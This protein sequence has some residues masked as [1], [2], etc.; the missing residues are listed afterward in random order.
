MYSSQT[1]EALIIALARTIRSL[2][3]ALSL[4]ILSTNVAHSDT[5]FAEAFDDLVESYQNEIFE[6]RPLDATYAGKPEFN[7]KFEIG[8]SPE[9]RQRTIVLESKYLKEVGAIM[10]SNLSFEDS[11]R[12]QEFAFYRSRGLE[13]LNYPDHLMPLQLFFGVPQELAHLASTTD[14]QPF[15]TVDDYIDWAERL[16]LSA[17]WYEQATANYKLGLGSGI[18]QPQIVAVKVT[19]ALESIFPNDFV[20][21]PFY[22]PI[23]NLPADFSLSDRELITDLYAEIY[24]DVLM[25]AVNNLTTYLRTTYI[26]Q[27][28]TSIGLS[29]VDGGVGWYTFLVAASTGTQLSPQEIHDIGLSEVKRLTSEMSALLAAQYGEL[30]FIEQISIARERLPFYKTEKGMIDDYRVAMAKYYENLASVFVLEHISLPN[31]SLIP[32][33]FSSTA[34]AAVYRPDFDRSDGVDTAA[35]YLNPSISLPIHQRDSLILHE[36]IPGHHLQ[37]STDPAWSGDDQYYGLESSV[38]FTE[39]WA[40]YAE[41]FGKEAG[42]YNSWEQNFGRLESLAFRAVRLVVDTGIHSKKWSYSKAVNYMLENTALSKEDVEN[43]VLRYIADPAQAL[44]YYM[45]MMEFQAQRR[46]ATDALGKRF[47]IKSFHSDLLKYGNVPL[48]LVSDIV[49]HHIVTSSPAGNP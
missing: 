29:E 6:L 12:A 23:L 26:K 22:M 36:T 44:S 4:S 37:S 46:R 38:A 27:T 32:A 19:E 39:G 11:F 5:R 21:S 47:D 8:I 20:D 10:D 34:P 28:R 3:P 14:A 1:Q 16:R 35:F 13:G 49:H 42:A 30:Q 40:M 15:S 45:G 7:N 43:E 41:G 33:Q 18:T 48:P 9:V 2:T 17:S 24:N 31:V 25:P